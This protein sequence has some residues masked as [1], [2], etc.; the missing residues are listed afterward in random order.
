MKP[1]DMRACRDCAHSHP[2][3]YTHGGLECLH[4]KVNE[5]NT[6]ALAAARRCGE[7]ALDER[8]SDRWIFW[9]KPCGRRGAL[10]E[11]K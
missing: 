6:W 5:R 3:A 2:S 11:A 10:W 4:P 8:R 7:D 1:S 9:V